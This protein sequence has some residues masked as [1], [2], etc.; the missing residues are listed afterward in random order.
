MSAVFYQNCYHKARTILFSSRLQ[1]L[2]VTNDLAGRYLN[3]C[4]AQLY[5]STS[6]GVFTA[7]WPLANWPSFQ[8]LKC[9]VKCTYYFY[10]RR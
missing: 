3:L 2:L 4:S 10:V 7:P 9:V 1:Y 6:G 5:H 8:T